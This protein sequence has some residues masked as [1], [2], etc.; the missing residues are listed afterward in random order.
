VT[1]GRRKTTVGR[2]EI[3]EALP[4]GLG[5][6]FLDEGK[7][8]GKKEQRTYF[9]QVGKEFKN[10]Y[11][12]VANKLKDLGNDYVYTTGF[13]V[14]LEDFVPERKIRDSVLQKA[15]AMLK[16]LPASKRTPEA[17]ISV[18]DKAT[19][20][21][22]TAVNKKKKQS[23]DTLYLLQA[24]G[25]K[26]GP[27]QYR[28][29]ALAP[30]LMSN[31]DGTIIPEPVR[32]SFAEGLPL[33]DYWTAAAGA[34]RG[35]IQK[36][37]SVQEPGAITKQMMNSV[38]DEVVISDDCGTDKGIRLPVDEDDNVTDR[39]LAQPIKAGKKTIPAGT[40]LTNDVVS[41][42]R[43][44]K[45]KDVTVRSPLRCAHG[46][47]MCATCHGLDE[48]G[49]LP[50]VGRNLGVIS[51]HALGERSTQL[52]L[53][54]FHGGG[55]IPPGH[56]L[57]SEGLL[58]Q[59]S[60]VQQLLTLP[61]RVPGA[62][63]LAK[64]DG[65]ITGIKKDPAGGHEVLVG[66]ERHYI[67]QDRGSPTL[68]SKGKSKSLQVGMPVK[69]GD[70]L[71]KGPVNPHELLELTNMDRVQ[72]YLSDELYGLYKDQGIDRRAVETV[73]RGVTNTGRVD[74]PGDIPG[75]TRGDA[76]PLSS[77]DNMNRMLPTGSKKMKI[78]PFLRG[79]NI[80]PLEKSEDWIARLNHQRLS[81]TVVEA[82][83]QGWKSSIHGVNPIPALIYGAELGKGKFY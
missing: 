44:N 7:E 6:Q 53:K 68:I 59:F 32:K 26:P 13:S 48:N 43:A 9:T 14:G 8:F 74:D 20:A 65:R 50:E 72:R 40:V 80:M 79:V 54:A 25:V 22:M 3:A 12:D 70:P 81:D 37:Q 82:A 17:K 38:M 5:K 61:A 56:A 11:G 41:D 75:F 28:Q 10:D 33:A 4:S 63:P 46:V 52:A 21:M 62:V 83:Q 18:Y 49:K 35:I 66:N 60:R 42:L 64:K 24:S 16:S 71:A 73:V 31:P 47:G 55:V 45:V 19:Q 29:L 1:I 2:M 67:P 15:D 58:D 30:M 23:P 36:T 27:L 39:V 69:K 77:A 78:E 51:A 76:V 57:K 34:R